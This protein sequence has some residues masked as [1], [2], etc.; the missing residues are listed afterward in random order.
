MKGSSSQFR[1]GFEEVFAAQFGRECLSDD[2]KY[3]KI[4]GEA[5]LASGN[6]LDF[7]SRQYLDPTTGLGTDKD[8]LP[9]H[10]V[11]IFDKAN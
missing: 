8:Y 2:P 4:I 3:C 5:D 1:D 10:R 6:L 7:M 11:L 9:G